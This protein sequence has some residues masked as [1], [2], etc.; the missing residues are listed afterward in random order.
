MYEWLRACE[1][2]QYDQP[3]D[4]LA[5]RTD[6]VTIREKEAAEKREEQLEAERKRQ[7]ELRKRESHRVSSVAPEIRNTERERERL[8]ENDCVCVHAW[9]GVNEEGCVTNCLVA[10]TVICTCV[11]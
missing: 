3:T 8:G 1:C 5:V 6:R 2:V 7:E 10:C 9:Q 11:Y 4:C